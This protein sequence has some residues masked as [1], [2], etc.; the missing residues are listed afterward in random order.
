MKPVNKISFGSFIV[1]TCLDAKGPS[2][3]HFYIFLCVTE[4]HPEGGTL[5]SKHFVTLKVPELIFTVVP[6]ILTLLKSFT[7]QLMH[8]GV[9]LKEY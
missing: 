1:E 5:R 3:E 6:C 9:A 8:N 7:Y 4:C 2:A